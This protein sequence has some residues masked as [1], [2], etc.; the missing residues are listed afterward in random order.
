MNIHFFNKMQGYSRQGIHNEN[1]K[2]KTVDNTNKKKSTDWVNVALF[3]LLIVVL[4]LIIIP[5]FIEYFKYNFYFLK[6]I[7]KFQSPLQ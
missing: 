4:A 7:F 6:N 2:A 5:Y 1:L 3:G